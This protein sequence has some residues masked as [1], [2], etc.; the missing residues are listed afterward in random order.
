MASLATNLLSSKIEFSNELTYEP[1]MAPRSSY[2]A[3][4]EVSGMQFRVCGFA[5][6]L[7]YL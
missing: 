2:L 3:R 4:L 7:C 1:D 6:K 5:P